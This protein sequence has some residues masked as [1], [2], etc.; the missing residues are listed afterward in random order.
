MHV[1]ASRFSNLTRREKV[2][3][4][5]HFTYSLIE[6]VIAG[7]IALNEFVFVKSL[8]GSGYQVSL[9]FQFSVV[10]F[11]LLIVFNE[12]LKRIKNVKKLLK[13]TAIITRLPLIFL[14]FFP[15]NPEQLTGSSI[16]HAVFLI[17]FLFYFLANP[18]VFPTINLFLKSS[19]RHLNFGRLYSYATTG[20]KVV[21]IATTFVYGWI[22][23]K[24]PFVFVYVFPV[25]AGLGVISL[26]VL[27]RIPYH[28]VITVKPRSSLLG[29]MKNSILEMKKVL[30]ENLPFRHFQI[31]FMLYGF[32]F[33]SSAMVIVLYFNEELRLNYT[34]V[35]FYRNAYNLLAIVTLPFFG[36]LIG[37]IDPR[38]FAGYSFLSMAL[39]IFSL[40]MTKFF[41][42]NVRIL[43]ITLYLT[44]V[45]YTIFHGIFA[46]TMS[47]T[48]SIGSAYFCKPQ[49]AGSYQSIHM[50]LTALR[51][52]VA[53]VLGI[54]SYQVFGF[55]PTFVIAIMFLISGTLFL[56]WS[57]KRHYLKLQK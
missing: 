36:T 30:T 28:E 17:I 1:I 41:D 22:L 49:E 3:F 56:V 8:L 29:G 45:F 42:M 35:A 27:S 31:G 32:G 50:V 37:K 51:A 19:Y 13:Y 24:D 5:L 33:M 54:T 38:R 2:T 34:S 4:S 40:V 6:G 16:Y 44:L 21:M 12:Y 47:L 18:I 55:Y 52:I 25:M 15:G 46:A 11:I 53:P 43:D 14:F 7:V 39:F 26:L 57:E 10:P 48:W 20:N 23:D 9:L